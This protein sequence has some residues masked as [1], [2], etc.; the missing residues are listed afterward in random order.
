VRYLTPS[1]PG[2][3]EK[4]HDYLVATGRAAV[5]PPTGA[6]AADGEVAVD[7]H[8]E[9]EAEADH[10]REGRRAAVGDQRQRHA[11]D[12]KQAH[13][14][15][16]VDEEIEEEG[17]AQATRVMQRASRRTALLAANLATPLQ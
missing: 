17:D 8:R 5:I 15:R 4:T 1:L 2:E 12:R 16:H 14:H 13:H 7:V 6:E 10:Q 3:D 9:D 11:D